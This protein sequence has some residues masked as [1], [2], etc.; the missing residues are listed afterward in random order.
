MTLD[1]DFCDAGRVQWKNT[2]DALTVRNT[3]HGEV[4]IDASTFASDHDAG[5]DLDTLFITFDNAGVDFDGVADLKF[6]ETGFE[7]LAFN[8]INDAHGWKIW[9]WLV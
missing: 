7:L 6:F 4:R 3:A 8:L 2:F 1:F 9:N 5:V